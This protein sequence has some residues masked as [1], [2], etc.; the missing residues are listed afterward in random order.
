MTDPKIP[1][2]SSPDLL[3]E[4][5][6]AAKS[7][8]GK[9][10]EFKKTYVNVRSKQSRDVRREKILEKHPELKEE[11]ERKQA[12][13]DAA[14]A[15]RKADLEAKKAERDAIR[16][17]RA[18]RIAAEELVKQQKLD[19]HNALMA[20]AGLSSEAIARVI[21]AGIFIKKNPDESISH[22]KVVVLYKDLMGKYTDKN[23]IIEFRETDELTKSTAKDRL[24][25]LLKEVEF[26]G[27]DEA[28]DI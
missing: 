4:A 23:E 6:E 13:R 19:A 25:A 18:A 27:M 2:L 20:E 17:A 5:L 15:K 22:A 16:D 7:L 28:L 9:D 10:P 21:K 12:E 26:V 8:A 14:S 11:A 3:R 24:I 1:V